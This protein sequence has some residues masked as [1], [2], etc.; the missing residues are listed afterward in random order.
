[1]RSE[2]HAFKRR[3]VRATAAFCRASSPV[4]VVGRS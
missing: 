3:V 2:R 4:A 1:M